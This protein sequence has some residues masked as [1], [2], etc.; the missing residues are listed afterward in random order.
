MKTI[1]IFRKPP[2][3]SRKSAKNDDVYYSSQWR[4]MYQRLKKHKLARVSLIVL[5]LFYLAAIFAQFIAPYGLQ[6]YDSKYV[7]APPMKIKFIDADGK[8]H[9]RPFV[10]ELKSGRD[11][12][13]FRKTFVQDDKI[14][15]SVR[16][17]VEGESYQFLGFIPTKTHLFGVDQPGRLFIFGTDGMGRDLFSRIVLGS[18]ISLSIPLIGVAIS[19]VLGLIIGGISGYFGG[20]LDSVIQRVIEIIR[21]FPTLPLWM[22]LSAAIPPRIPV[23]TMYLYI[24][25]IFAFIGWTDLAR[26]ARGKFISL[27]NEEYVLAAKIAGVSDTK[28]IVKHL[29]PGF[30]SYLVVA[31][32]LAIPG[33]ILGE[34]AMSFL[35]LG[36]RSPATSWGVLLQEAQQIDNVALYPWKLIPLGFVIITVLTFNFLGD[37]LRDAADPYKR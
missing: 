30:I 35:G 22:A 32:T 7:N 16:F 8:F 15:Y 27:K 13:T 37:G 3:I 34:T 6:S 24:V 19:F 23:V 31:T 5:S 36:I 28:I 4:L 14:K 20:W 10:H 29:L 11:P 33:M 2:L 17:L 26:V 12:V 9:F 25:I 21:S 18:Q 1:T